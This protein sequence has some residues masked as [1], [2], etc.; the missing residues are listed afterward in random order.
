MVLPIRAI[1]STIVLDH[2]ELK[3]WEQCLSTSRTD[4]IRIDQAVD[5]LAQLALLSEAVPASSDCHPFLQ[6]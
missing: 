6:T 2:N 4:R 1:G 3:T 5:D